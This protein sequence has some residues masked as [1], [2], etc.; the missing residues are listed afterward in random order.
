MTTNPAFAA[1]RYLEKLHAQLAALPDGQRR[2]IVEGVEEHIADALAEGRDIDEVLTGLGSPDQ[3]AAQYGEE[4][5]ARV[6]PDPS[7]RATRLLSATAALTAIVAT[8]A[9]PLL[10]GFDGF[11]SAIDIASSIAMFVVPVVLAALPLVLPRASGY[12]VAALGAVAVTALALLAL[13]GM[14]PDAS[15]LSQAYLLLPV[16]FAMCATAIVP[17]VTRLSPRWRTGSRMIGAVLTMIPAVLPLMGTLSGAVEMTWVPLVSAAVGLVMGVLYAWGHRAV[18]I[19]LATLGAV[20]L[21]AALIDLGMMFLAFWVVGGW[22]LAL[23]MGGFAALSS[24]AR[25]V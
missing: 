19:V 2:V 12:V 11:A 9:S 7:R 6:G 25:R 18:C 5:G 23:G 16:G 14:L 3:V 4:L 10:L 24:R 13:V 20:V 1:E 21:I 17:P 15:P 22:W 8:G